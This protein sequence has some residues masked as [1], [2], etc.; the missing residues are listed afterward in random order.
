M[1]KKFEV[2]IRQNVYAYYWLRRIYFWY[3]YVFRTSHEPEFSILSRIPTRPGEIIDVGAND[4]ISAI[5]IR[6]FNQKNP[7][8]SFEP[9]RFYEGRLK[10]ISSRLTN[11]SYQMVGIGEAACE[12]KLYIPVYKGFVLTALGALSPEYAEDLT[13]RGMFVRNFDAKQL[14]IEPQT[15]QIIRIDDLKLNPV[16][17]KIDIEGGELPALRGMEET[18]KRSRPVLI[19]EHNNQGAVEKNKFLKNLAYDLIDPKTMRFP[20]SER[21]SS[22]VNHVFWPRGLKYNLPSDT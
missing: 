16:L 21:L 6:A 14:R 9:N 18:L 17:V 7:I 13:G 22:S 15:I 4:G 1:I 20:S 5:S 10:W 19:I 8:L 11:F 2:L 3:C 12:T